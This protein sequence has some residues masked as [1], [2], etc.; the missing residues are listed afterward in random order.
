MILWFL[1]N[2]DTQ[3]AWVLHCLSKCFDLSGRKKAQSAP[4]VMDSILENFWYLSF[5]SGRPE[6][7]YLWFHAENWLCIIREHWESVQWE[8]KALN[9]S[10]GIVS[11]VV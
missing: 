10:D 11:F 7:F 6:E 2:A 8:E 9:A 5:K 1:E 4:V 3:V